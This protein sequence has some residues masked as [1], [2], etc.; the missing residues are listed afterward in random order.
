MKNIKAALI[1]MG[2][3]CSYPDGITNIKDLIDFLNKNYHSFAELE[4]LTNSVC[5]GINPTSSG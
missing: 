1:N 3:Y 4:F 2:N 5:D